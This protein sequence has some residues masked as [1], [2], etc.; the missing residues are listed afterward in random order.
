[1]N[2]VKNLF[3]GKAS[4]VDQVKGY[5]QKVVLINRKDL[6][7]YFIN[8]YINA[9]NL[10]LGKSA[11]YIQFKLK[12]NTGYPFEN[13]TNVALIN[14]QYISKQKDDIPRY[15]HK[16]QF[17]LMGVDQRTKMILHSMNWADYFAALRHNSGEVEIFGF[18]FGLRPTNLTIDGADS[19]GIVTLESVEDEFLP[20]FKYISPVIGNTDFDFDNNWSTITVVEYGEFDDSYDDSFTI[21]D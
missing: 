21:V 8:S 9:N 2:H 17:S 18:E 20:P 13:K 5:E 1:M 19:G 12:S 15:T 3:A 6:G 7:D 14:A 16:V 10:N 11:N 4:C